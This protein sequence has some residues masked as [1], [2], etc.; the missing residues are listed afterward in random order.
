MAQERPGTEV[1]E[2]R[3]TKVL[4]NPDISSTSFDK[5]IPFAS[6]LILLQI[7]YY[8]S[9][10]L[11]THQLTPPSFSIITIHEESVKTGDLLACAISSLA[12][13]SSIKSEQIL[14]YLG[15]TNNLWSKLSKELPLSKWKQRYTLRLIEEKNVTFNEGLQRALTRVTGTFVGFLQPNE[16]YLDGSL[17]NVEKYFLAHPEIDVLFTGAYV[18]DNIAKKIILHP[19]TL[20]SLEYLWIAEPHFLVS[21]FFFRTSLLKEG[22]FF[23]AEDKSRM[24]RKWL[25]QLLQAGKKIGTLNIPTTWSLLGSPIDDLQDPV[26]PDCPR[27]IK[28][29]SSLWKLQHVCGLKK[30]K[31]HFLPLMPCRI[32]QP[33]SLTERTSPDLSK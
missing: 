10:P 5:G 19:P 12:D 2:S 22:F 32:Y 20:F 4:L 7:D 6:F 27:I 16:Q 1:I 21:T 9:F 30:A 23:D 31:R 14:Q 18:H 24:F 28:V 13:Q 3:R 29:L 11:S 15:A 17:L 25:L 33:N 8:M 26:L